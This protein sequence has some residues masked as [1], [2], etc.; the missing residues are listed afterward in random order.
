MPEFRLS[1]YNIAG[2]CRQTKKKSEFSKHCKYLRHRIQNINWSSPEA[3]IVPWPFLLPSLQSGGQRRDAATEEKLPHWAELTSRAKYLLPPHVLS[4][5]G[6]CGWVLRNRGPGWLGRRRD[7]CCC[8]P[9]S[10]IITPWCHDFLSLVV[11]C[12]NTLNMEPQRA[13]ELHSW[14]TDSTLP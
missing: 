2:L 4:P 6:L 3:G 14:D 9:G 7:Q 8:Q 12:L 10:V 13:W 11:S 1:L 5:G